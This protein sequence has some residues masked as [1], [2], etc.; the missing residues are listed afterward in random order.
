MR[1]RMPNQ[2]RPASVEATTTDPGPMVERHNAAKR[3]LWSW[4][5]LAE[6][7]RR[8]ISALGRRSGPLKGGPPGSLE[9]GS[10]GG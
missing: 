10:G 7:A 1:Q 8:L 4:S 9:W 6:A 3:E 5:L 2:P